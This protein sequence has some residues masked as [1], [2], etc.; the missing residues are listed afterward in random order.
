MLGFRVQGSRVS[1]DPVS[2]LK[3]KRLMR[4][5]LPTLI[6]KTKILLL[7]V[8]MEEGAWEGKGFRV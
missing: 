5:M 6:F 2:S 4:V 1:G 7:H 3:K 8:Q